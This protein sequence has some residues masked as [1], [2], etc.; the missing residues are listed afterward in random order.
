MFRDASNDRLEPPRAGS[1]SRGSACGRPPAPERPS[2]KPP[3]PLPRFPESISPPP[4]LRSPKCPSSGRAPSARR[5]RR[6]ARALR[7]G[8]RDR[9]GPAPHRRPQ[10][11]F[12]GHAAP[13]GHRPVR[14]RPRTEFFARRIKGA[15]TLPRGSAAKP[16]GNR[17]NRPDDARIRPIRR[18]KRRDFNRCPRFGL[19]RSM[20]G[21]SENSNLQINNE[22]ESGKPSKFLSFFCK[23]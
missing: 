16:V 21:Q 7:A 22:N 5:P 3:S 1:P 10:E 11:Q 8:R 2:A 19:A 20:M 13:A 15:G 18:E 9:K 23:N 12:A 14:P 6:Q 4:R 17:R